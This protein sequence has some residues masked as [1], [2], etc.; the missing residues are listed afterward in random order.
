M[1]RIT[2]SP[3]LSVFAVLALIIGL[4]FI[5]A[6]AW[7]R[8]LAEGIAAAKAGDLERAVERYSALEK[9]FDRIPI[10]KQIFPAVYRASITNQLQVQYHMGEHD[11]VI[12]KAASSL[13]APGIHFWAGCSLFEKARGVEKREERVT[14]LNRAEDEF[15]KSLERQPD[16]WD[17]KFNYEVTKQ[18]LTELRQQKAQPPPQQFLPLL[19]PKPTIVDR[20]VKRI[21]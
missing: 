7:T 15:K 5:A 11:V 4:A 3:V 12:E 9:R 10:T 16:D 17:T 14:W 6:A 2:V 18:L 13:S 20:P 21:G 1:R 8:P 19:R